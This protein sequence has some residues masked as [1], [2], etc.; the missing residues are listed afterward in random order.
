MKKYVSI[1][2]ILTVCFGMNAD[3]AQMNAQIRNLLQQKEDKVKQLEECEGKKKGWMIA[4]I[5]TIGVTA[6]G[7]GVN[8]AQA[9]KRKNLDTEIESQRS[10]LEDKENTLSDLNNQIAEKERRERLK[11]EKDDCNS[12]DGKH[13]EDKTAE[14]VDDVV[15]VPT[16]PGEKIPVVGNPDG[17]IGE[18]CNDDKGVWTEKP[19][20]NKNC[21]NDKGLV[22]CECVEEKKGEAPRDYSGY[23]LDCK[24]TRFEFAP[25]DNYQSVYERLNGQCVQDTGKTMVKTVA[26]HPGATVWYECVGYSDIPKCADSGEPV[27]NG[28]LSCKNNIFVFSVTPAGLQ[29]SGEYQRK[30]EVDFQGKWQSVVNTSG[31]GKQIIGSVKYECTDMKKCEEPKPE[32]KPQI[33]RIIGEKCLPGDLVMPNAVEGK[34]VAGKDWDCLEAKGSD[35]I[36]KCSCGVTKCDESRGFLLR[37]GQCVLDDLKKT[38]SDCFEK[39]L[40]YVDKECPDCISS[41]NQIG[42]AL[43]ESEIDVAGGLKNV[44]RSETEIGVNSYTRFILNSKN[45]KTMYFE[46]PGLCVPANADEIAACVDSGGQWEAKAKNQCWCGYNQSTGDKNLAQ[47]EDFKTCKCK[48]GYVLVDENFP[49]KGCRL[50]SD[51]AA[52][53]LVIN[54]VND[55]QSKWDAMNTKVKQTKTASSNV[56]SSRTVD[57]ADK[58]LKQTEKYGSE[59]VKLANSA[60][61]IYASV[62]KEYNK[63]NNDDKARVK[64]DKDSADV[65]KKDIDKVQGLATQYI[66]DARVSFSKAIEKEEAQKNA[67]AERVKADN[68]IDTHGHWNGKSCDCDPKKFLEPNPGKANT[69]RCMQPS[70]SKNRYEWHD[71]CNMCRHPN[72]VDKDLDCGGK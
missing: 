36:V 67:N 37:D 47:T 28:E 16:E 52:L 10:V 56:A 40:T 72:A 44:T 9:S 5:S 11:K 21:S 15:E 46:C 31:D 12:I 39:V 62:M 22:P 34:Y 42:R 41:W 19:N 13:W 35:K 45:G 66:N 61:D 33:N 50:G 65:M 30:C 26:Q 8:I 54:K 6:V 14:C 48:K 27:K 63:L 70:N 57:E 64:K 71:K 23:V 51:D 25:N 29:E 60:G 20:G 24:H 7:V 58:F 69:C 2:S 3:A 43:C 53:D 17:K 18:K 49:I 55:L 4:G 68:C 59:A 1:L 32:P 38:E